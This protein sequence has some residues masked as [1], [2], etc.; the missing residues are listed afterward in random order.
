[1]RELVARI[2][3]F[4]DH[5]NSDATPSEWTA[6]AESI[7]EKLQNLCHYIFGTPR[8]QCGVDPGGER[9]AVQDL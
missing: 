7:F 2:E 5:Y 9:G 4:R 6:T 8:S 1:M 3:T